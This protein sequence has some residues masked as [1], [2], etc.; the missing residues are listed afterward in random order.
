[1]MPLL[2]FMGSAGSGKGTQ[3]ERLVEHFGY[4]WIETG[5]LIRAKAQEAS[6]LGRRIKKND[7]LGKHAPD[8][9][10][11]TLLIEYFS[12]LEEKPG[13]KDKPL[14]V[15]GFPRTRK[16]LDMLDEVLRY[17]DRDPQALK[18]LWIH[19]PQ[20]VARARLQNRAL[21]VKCK[22][23]FASRDVKECDR[24]GGEVKP[25]VYDTDKGIEE[26]LHFY[27]EQTMPAIDAYRSQ[28]RLIEINGHQAVDDVW[29]EIQEALSRS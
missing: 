19:V 27:A 11:T 21:C 10:I 13:M 5:N 12:A 22:K 20:D 15:D 6:P 7:D 14:L 28:G 24:C 8:T 3:A 9:I 2:V 4:E 1:M 16:Q 26:R 25:R 18:A 17:F 29:K 23:I